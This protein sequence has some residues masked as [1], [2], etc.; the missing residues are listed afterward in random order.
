M[1]CWLLF[2]LY[3]LRCLGHIQ[4][5]FTGGKEQR[6]EEE[7]EAAA[8]TSS[9]VATDGIEEVVV[10]TGEGGKDRVETV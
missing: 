8:D 3:C 4:P 7:E 2:D 10:D 9:L 5:A 6:Q 1:L